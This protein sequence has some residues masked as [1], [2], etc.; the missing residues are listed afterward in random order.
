M[1]LDS[2]SSLVEILPFYGELDEGYRI[3]GM[4]NLRTQQIWNKWRTPLG[5]IIKRKVIQIKQR[6]VFKF[7]L[8]DSEESNELLSIFK[9][10]SVEIKA[11]EEYISFIDWINRCKYISLVKIKN[12]YLHLSSKD[13]FDWTYEEACTEIIYEDKDREVD[14]EYNKLIELIYSKNVNIENVKSFLYSGE[15][16]NR[17]IN[18]LDRA[19][20]LIKESVK[21]EHFIELKEKINDLNVKVNKV[22][23]VLDSNK[24]YDLTSAFYSFLQNLEGLDLKS[25]ELIVNSAGKNNTITWD[26]F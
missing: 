4:I 17:K 25:I 13:N 9:I 10:E 16:K 22:W 15:I 1:K 12:L 6:N 14:A 18:F 21:H 26:L 20:I 19:I 7:L 11:L 8:E 2:I 24:C 23:V 5:K 3:M